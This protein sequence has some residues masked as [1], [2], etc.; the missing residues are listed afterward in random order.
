V[1]LVAEDD[2][3]IRDLLV[4]LLTGEGCRVVAAADGAGALREL[5]A[6]GARPPAVIL[7]DIKM[8]RMGRSSPPRTGTWPAR[9]R[10][11]SP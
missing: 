1:V 7:L 2:E 6:M 3:T 11:S 10:R 5:V 8:P 4:A 9:T